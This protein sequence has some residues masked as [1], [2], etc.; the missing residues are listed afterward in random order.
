M[1]LITLVVSVSRHR[2]VPVLSTVALALLLVVVSGTAQSFPVTLKD[3]L[4]HSVTLS[5]PPQRIISLAPS[6]TEVLFALGLGHRVIAV[7]SDSNYPAAVSQK[8]RVGSGLAPSLE[9][10]VALQPDLV[11]L[12]DASAKEIQTKLKQLQINT[13]TFTPQNLTEVYG[14]IG[15]V[16]RLTGTEE[17]AQAVVAGMQE[18]VAF[19][20][21][22]VNGSQKRPLVFYEVWP[23]PLYSAGPGSFI[24]ELITLAGGRNVAAGARSAWPAISVETAIAGDPEVIITPF[25]KNDSVVSGKSKA[26]W[27]NVKAVRLGRICRVDQDIV[28]RPGPRLADGLLAIAK[29]LHPGFF[30]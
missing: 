25:D 5:A 19:V 30:D 9:R 3:D 20:T 12:W 28:S 23:E 7:D 1:S 26:L 21:Q 6:N 14:Y 17:A 16:G 11:L 22:R 29:A 18:R 2:L 24:H 4:G 15:N 8:A 10:I 13:A 27:A